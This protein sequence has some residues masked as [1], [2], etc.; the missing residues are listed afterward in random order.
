ME[1]TIDIDPQTQTFT[2]TWTRLV[3][4]EKEKRHQ[5]SPDGGPPTKIAKTEPKVEVVSTGRIPF[6]K[7]WEFPS[8]DGFEHLDERW[9]RT[10]W[11]HRH[12]RKWYARDPSKPIVWIPPDNWRAETNEEYAERTKGWLVG[13]VRLEHEEVEVGG[14]Y[15]LF[16]DP[17]TKVRVTSLD[18]TNTIPRVTVQYLDGSGEWDLFT[19]ELDKTVLNTKR[20]RKNWR[21]RRRARL[22]REGSY[23]F[24]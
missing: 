5:E 1:K 11:W 20:N 16:E 21:N 13:G 24:W 7:Y 15:R 18:P 17:A 14:I 19:D 2:I 3:T 4:P 23:F 9:L 10:V 12:E 6:G 22:R 8:E